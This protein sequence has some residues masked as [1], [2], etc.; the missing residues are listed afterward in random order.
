M[1]LPGFRTKQ[2]VFF[3]RVLVYAT[4]CSTMN[5]KQSSVRMLL[6]LAKYIWLNI[7]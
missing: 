3:A 1:S 5:I 2:I 6:I 4:N 7:K